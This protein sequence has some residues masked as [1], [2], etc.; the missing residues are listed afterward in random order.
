[1][2]NLPAVSLQS[3]QV[4]FDKVVML[5]GVTGGVGTGVILR[6]LTDV[7]CQLP[8]LGVSSGAAILVCFPFFTRILHPSPFIDIQAPVNV[9]AHMH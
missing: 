9:C 3:C 5:S 8:A 6:A 4:V 2:L 1:M 7:Q